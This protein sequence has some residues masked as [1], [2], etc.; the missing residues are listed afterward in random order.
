MSSKLCIIV[1]SGE[2]GVIKTALQYARR[3]VTESFME[4]TKLFLFGPSED[5]IA[6][7]TEL[8]SFVKSFMQETGRDI[9][10][11]RWCAEDYGVSGKLEE[12]NVKVDFIGEQVSQTIRE[13]YVPMVW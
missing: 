10:A 3:T 11:C 8:Q 4:D 7:D 9:L 2:K 13:G 5:V 1:S 6:Y 12:M